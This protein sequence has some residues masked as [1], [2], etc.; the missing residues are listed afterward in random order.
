MVSF[1]SGPFNIEQGN[2]ANFVI[3]FF[4][5]NGILSIPSAP[6]MTVTYVNTSAATQVDTV[7]L[8][9]NGSFYTGTWSSTSASLGLATWLTT[10]PSSVQVATGQLR[11]I[12]RVA[13]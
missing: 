6:A 1:Q 10:A 7:A 5:I 3:E 11:I 13:I 12:Q 2:S 8:S 4:D 9:Q